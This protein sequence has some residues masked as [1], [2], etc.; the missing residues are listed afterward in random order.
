MAADLFLCVGCLNIQQ[1]TQLTV[2]LRVYEGQICRR[3]INCFV[4]IMVITLNCCCMSVCMGAHVC[5][6]TVLCNLK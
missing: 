1:S 5:I 3:V 6:C 4:I 2:G